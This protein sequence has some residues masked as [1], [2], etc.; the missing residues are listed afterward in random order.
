MRLRKLLLAPILAL[1]LSQSANG[2]LFGGDVAVLMQILVQ[3]MQ[4]VL[5]LKSILET[6]HDTLDLLHDVNS[7]IKAGLDVIHIINPKVNPGVYGSL[8]NPDAVLKALQDVYGQVPDGM[9]HELIQSQDQSVAEVISMNRNLY[10]YADQVDRE[11]DR[12]MFHAQVVSPQG[13]GKLQN[14]AL[15]V[16]IGVTT[17][18]LR[19]QSQMLKLL[20]Q[21]MAMQTRKEKVSTEN[22]KS[23]YDG[24]SSGF[25]GLPKNS[26]LPR[27]GGDQ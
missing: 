6:G 21:N 11:R 13:A 19:T 23:N 5:Q 22:F 27:L 10:D 25:K 12:I 17:Q 15:G 16:L 26:Q 3:A 14:Q 9:D 20:A 18:L 24:L 8:D 7:G 4:T 2:D 1:S